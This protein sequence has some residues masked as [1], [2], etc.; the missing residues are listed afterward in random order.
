MPSQARLKW[1]AERA[2]ALDKIER[3]HKAVGGRRRGRRY[4]TEQINSAYAVLLSSH[5]Q[6]FCRDLH[7]EAADHIIQHLNIVDPA[8]RVVVRD[9]FTFGRRVDSG[10]PNPGNLGNDF[11][12]LGIVKFWDKVKAQH[13]RNADR[14]KKLEVLN[15]WRNAI[16][17]QNVNPPTIGN[18]TTLRLSD[19]RG[20]RSACDGLVVAF[21]DV[22]RA[23][24]LALVGVAP[25]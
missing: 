22:V 12:R 13:A 17:H 21:D 25:W 5:F 4:A 9:Q 16:A 3:A 24:L 15:E 14:Q 10:N 19:V 1:D 20:W 11:L 23:H 2:E 7:T 18:R 8:V 6:G